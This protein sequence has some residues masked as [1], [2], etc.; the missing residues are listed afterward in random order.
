MRRVTE[1][2]RPESSWGSR[3]PGRRQ[4]LTNHFLGRGYRRSREAGGDTGQA[5][6]VRARRRRRRHLR[7]AGAGRLD[8]L[9]AS[10]TGSSATP[11]RTTWRAPSSRAIPGRTIPR[12][13]RPPA[14]SIG[15]FAASP[16]PTAAGSS[17]TPT[18]LPRHRRHPRSAH[19]TCQARAA[20]S[21]RRP[22]P[23]RSGRTP[24]TILATNNISAAG[25]LHIART[26]GSR[27]P[28]G[29]ARSGLTRPR[30][31]LPSKGAI[32]QAFPDRQGSQEAGLNLDGLASIDDRP[33]ARLLE[34]GCDRSHAGTWPRENGGGHRRERVGH[35]RPDPDLTPRPETIGGESDI[36][37]EHRSPPISSRPSPCMMRSPG[38]P[39]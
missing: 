10:R 27:R 2:K 14:A 7:E 19:A 11:R 5:P 37:G 28:D 26:S 12:R 32:V 25:G 23:S 38:R 34:N 1:S 15:S 33:A 8:R 9:M 36:S 21:Q 39:R 13:R 20:L 31:V 18:A 22:S 3:T 24:T 17:A 16:T 30:P 6:G 35:R 29:R 4:G